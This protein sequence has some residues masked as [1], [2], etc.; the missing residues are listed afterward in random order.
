[1]G[2]IHGLFGVMTGKVADVVMA[3]RGGEQIV[4]KYQPVVFN[5]NT[6]GQIESRAKLKLLSQLSSVLAPAIAM[7]KDGNVSSR[8]KFTKE[9]YGLTSYAEGTA[10]ITLANVKLTKGVVGIP[11]LAITRAALTITAALQNPLPNFDRV[12]YVV[13]AKQ[14]DNELRLLRTVVSSTPGPNSD[15]TTEIPIGTNGPIVTYAYAIRLNSESA[16]AK[17]GNITAEQAETFAK[18]IATRVLTESDVTITETVGLESPAYA[19]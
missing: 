11:A 1:M 13:L 8:N 12:V 10:Q 14:A 7:P 17:Y 4:R 19:G 18:L 9:N 6:T 5:P 15:Y 2:K 3:V 16:K